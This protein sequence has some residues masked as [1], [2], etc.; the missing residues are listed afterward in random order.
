MTF[1]LFSWLPFLW[2]LLRKSV[3]HRYRNFHKNY[4]NKFKRQK[5]KVND[6]LKRER[7]RKK[8][9]QRFH[10]MK[11]I[12]VR[13][14]IE[15]YSTNEQLISIPIHHYCTPSA[16]KSEIENVCVL[17][18]ENSHLF[19]C[20]IIIN[21]HKY[22]VGFLLTFINRTRF[23]FQYVF[24]QLRSYFLDCLKCGGQMRP[25]KHTKLHRE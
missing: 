24:L 2:T 5:R 12:I 11:D 14:S 23:H 17:Y 10:V 3:A 4:H 6:K 18:H 25:H 16:F 1:P 21:I 19:Q 20:I 9:Q 7:A 13:Y 15:A 22:C 8:K